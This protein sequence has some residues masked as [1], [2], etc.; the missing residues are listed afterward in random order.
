MESET[1]FAARICARKRRR[2]SS[3]NPSGERSPLGFTM[4]NRHRGSRGKGIEENPNG[5][6]EFE[7][8]LKFE[9][10]FKI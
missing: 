7:G 9:G 8:I 3:K 6:D 1:R 10:I 4:G 2:D 5:I